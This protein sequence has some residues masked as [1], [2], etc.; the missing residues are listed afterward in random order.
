MKILK[1]HKDH[2]NL[3][4]IFNLIYKYISIFVDLYDGN[5]F[6]DLTIVFDTV[7]ILDFPLRFP[8]ESFFF[9]EVSLSRK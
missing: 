9:I 7:C 2:K 1:A 6:R 3:K 5:L 8:H 4:N